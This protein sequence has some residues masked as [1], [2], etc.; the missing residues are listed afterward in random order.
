MHSIRTPVPPPT[1]GSALGT[2]SILGLASHLLLR[3]NLGG[4]PSATQGFDQLNARHHLLHSEIHRRLLV[5]QQNGLGRNHIQVGVK[6]G[7]IPNLG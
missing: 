4:I 1:D 5:G 3:G 6:A 2:Q 7:L